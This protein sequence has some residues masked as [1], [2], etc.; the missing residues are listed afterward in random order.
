M[1]TFQAQ[2]AG[3]SGVARATLI[4]WLARWAVVMD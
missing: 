2:R 4:D 1:Q 3:H